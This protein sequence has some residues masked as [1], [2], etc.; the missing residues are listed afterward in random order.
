MAP[1]HVPIKKFLY[2][3]LDTFWGSK[4]NLLLSCAEMI[5]DWR[6]TLLSFR[7]EQPDS[8]KKMVAF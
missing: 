2:L 4:W 5:D 6:L 7:L 3:F 8:V 1:C